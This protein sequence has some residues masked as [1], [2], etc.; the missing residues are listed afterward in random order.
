VLVGLPLADA[1]QVVPGV[2]GLKLL[3]SGPPPPNPAEVLSSRAARELLTALQSQYDVVL[4]DCPPVLPVTDATVLATRVD[5]ILV[6]VTPG[7]TNRSALHRAGQLLR[8]VDAPI[9]GAVLNGVGLGAGY[10]YGYGYGADDRYTPNGH[11]KEESRRTRR[12]PVPRE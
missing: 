11:A 9:V 6:V 7:T 8:Q 5:A 1:I 3:A 2:P 10:G 12:F 4:I